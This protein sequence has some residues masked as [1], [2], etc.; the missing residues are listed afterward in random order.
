MPGPIV[1]STVGATYTPACRLLGILWEGS[2]TAG[3]RV[4]I[5][6]PQTNAL[7]CAL[8]TADSNSCL[9]ITFPAKGIAAPFGF[10]L[11]T[12]PASQTIQVYL[13]EL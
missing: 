13:M 8:R 11:T 6:C 5:R 4:E 12:A 10:K 9:G 7:L 3:D 1:L 2:T